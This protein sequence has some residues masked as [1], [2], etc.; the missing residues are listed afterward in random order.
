MFLVFLVR[1]EENTAVSPWW[2]QG[3]LAD[4]DTSMARAGGH[5]TSS[6]H[7]HDLHYIAATLQRL[8]AQARTAV[9]IDVDS[10]TA[11]ST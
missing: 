3:F 10:V 8:P 7:C 2:E 6:R 5:S 9:Q 1:W 4:N 11:H